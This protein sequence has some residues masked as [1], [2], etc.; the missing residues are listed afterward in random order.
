MTTIV[1]YGAGNLTS[2]ALA[3]KALGEEVKTTRDPAEI[4]KA[5]RIVF[6]GV[7][8][9]G[10]AMASLKSSGLEDEVKKAA[11]SGKPFLGICLG[12]QILFDHSEE[13]GGTKLLGILPGRVRR[14]PQVSG[15]KIPQIGWNSV[16]G[17]A[18]P[19]CYYFVHSYYAEKGENTIGISEYAGVEFS[20]A[21]AKENILACQFHPEKSGRAGMTLLRKWLEG[22]VETSPCAADESGETAPARGLS[23]R[24]IPCLDVRNGRV[25]KGVKFKN[26]IDLGDPVEMALAYSDGGADEL[27]FYDITASAERRPIDIGMVRSVAEAI[28][29]P[30]AVGGGISSLGDMERVILS[31]AEK[32]SVNSLAVKNP[33]IIAEGAKTFGRQC[34]VLGM[35][36][37]KSGG[38]KCPS[39]YEITTRGFR[40]YTGIDAVEWA[41]R[42]EDLGAGEIVVNSVDA[43]GTRAGFNLEVT[44]LMADAVSIPVVASGGAGKPEHFVE[45]FEK[46]KADAAI[47]AGMIHTGEWKIADIKKTMQSAG[48]RTRP[49]DMV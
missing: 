38:A 39:G 11:A 41:R 10:E 35:D 49:A 24:V 33:E 47:V 40:E 22:R 45:V 6:P 29:I 27:V 15:C 5:S 14:F 26:N 30:F 23:K 2:V 44:R 12:M 34:M 18:P 46:A 16:L 43:D 19:A 7:G 20:A 21:V 25:T 13:D 9:A 17:T 36:P 37:V 8:A 31:G 4:E 32:I 1:D 42:A 28:R 48:I 3:L